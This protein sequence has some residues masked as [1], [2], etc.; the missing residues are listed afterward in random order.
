MKRAIIVK[1]VPLLLL[2]ATLAF[3]GTGSN[4]GSYGTNFAPAVLTGQA[5]K[6]GAPVAG[7]TV[8]TIAGHTT[9]T[10]AQGTYTLYLDAPGIYTVTA[11]KGTDTVTQQTEVALGYAHRAPETTHE[12]AGTGSQELYLTGYS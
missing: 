5:T 7:A 6:A 4:L 1:G 9:T 2:V 8:S 10:D 11:S 3:A 12:E